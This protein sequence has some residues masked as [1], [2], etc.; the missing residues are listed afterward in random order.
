MVLE[1][2]SSNENAGGHIFNVFPAIMVRDR[3]ALGS[4]EDSFLNIDFELVQNLFEEL[5]A[6]PNLICRVLD[7]SSCTHSNIF[8]QDDLIQTVEVRGQQLKCNDFFCS[9]NFEGKFPMQ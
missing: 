4:K 3:K 2:L 8:Q 6:K 1:S 9:V 5:I 7:G